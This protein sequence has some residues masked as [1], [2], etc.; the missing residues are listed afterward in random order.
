MGLPGNRR[1]GTARSQASGEKAG[2]GRSSKAMNLLATG[3]LS[4][5]QAFSTHPSVESPVVILSAARVR[6]GG[7]VRSR[8]IPIVAPILR[9]AQ[10]S[11]A[12]LHLRAI[13]SASANILHCPMYHIVV[14]KG[15]HEQE[16]QE[17][18]QEKQ[19]QESCGTA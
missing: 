18:R 15:G 4:E 1:E 17:E 16:E 10:L 2:F 11:G 9:A 13:Y 12:C 14:L 5:L 8:R 6:R 3:A 19:A 7:R